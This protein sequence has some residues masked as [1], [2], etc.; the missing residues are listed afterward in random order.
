MW[1]RVDGGVE[2]VRVATV[3]DGVEVD[4]VVAL[5][6]GGDGDGARRL[7]YLLRCD[8]AWSVRDVELHATED[9]A[10]LSLHAEAAGRWRDASPLL[11]GCVDVDLEAVVFTNTLPIRRLSLRVGESAVLDVAFVRLPSMSLVPVQQRYTRVARD[12]YR[13]E[14]L[15]SGFRAD[16]RVDDDGLVVDYPGLARRLWAA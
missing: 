11:D 5:R 15:G 14:S 7:R 12:V 4:G 3:G 13:Y 6:G 9:G 10:S 16:L 1:R 8:A 2:H